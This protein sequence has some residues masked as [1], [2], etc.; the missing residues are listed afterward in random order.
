MT[1]AIKFVPI[2]IAA[3]GM[4]NA[5]HAADGNIDF[6]GKL[7]VQTCT[8]KVNGIV[9]PAA[10]VSLPTLSASL[11]DAVGKVAG[12]TNFDIELSNCTGQNI[13]MVKAFFEA[14]AD[15]DPISGQLINRGDA[16]NVRLQLL[17]NYSGIGDPIK[18]GDPS[19]L[20][21]TSWIPVPF[22]DAVLPYSVQ[23]FATGT[24]T[25][26]SVSSNV[27]YSINYQ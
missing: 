18:V 24:A 22:A 5:V 8:I 14:G 25:A 27:T 12:Q 20:T 10:V 1:S 7:Y 13:H 17:D 23:Y 3:V 15:V 21:R 19:Q 26:G 16:T 2:V 4:M 9:T 11:L 6:Q